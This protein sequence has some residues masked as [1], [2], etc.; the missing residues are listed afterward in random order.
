ME[1]KKIP[2]QVNIDDVLRDFE[3]V[4]GM[5]HKLEFG[6]RAELSVVVGDLRDKKKTLLFYRGM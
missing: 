5:S 1:R 4:R 3:G 2:S 6:I